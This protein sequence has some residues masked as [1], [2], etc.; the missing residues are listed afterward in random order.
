[1]GG[2]KTNAE[3]AS[4]KNYC[5]THFQN[6]KCQKGRKETMML[7]GGDSREGTFRTERNV[8]GDR[9]KKE[10]VAPVHEKDRLR[11]REGASQER[12]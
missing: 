7:S 4:I 3:K 11:H 12:K 9:A 1:M 8:R 2:C 5:Q 10:V 6:G